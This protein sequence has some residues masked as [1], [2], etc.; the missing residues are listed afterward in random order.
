MMEKLTMVMISE[1]IKMH[2][3]NQTETVQKEE[4]LQTDIRIENINNGVDIYT[5]ATYI[6]SY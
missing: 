3:I 5:I 2:S 6:A 1:N 4:Q